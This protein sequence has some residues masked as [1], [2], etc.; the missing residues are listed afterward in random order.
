[1][2]STGY[3]NHPSCTPNNK[4]ITAT[5]TKA[6]EGVVAINVDWIDDEWVV[7]SPLKL[8]QKIYIEN[9]GTFSVEDTGSFTEQNFHFDYWNVDIYFDEY[10]E[11]KEWGIQRVK[12]FILKED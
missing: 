5:Q 9:V 6:H 11:A 2:T 1:M 3:T 7:K 12:V 10:N 8:G 4:G